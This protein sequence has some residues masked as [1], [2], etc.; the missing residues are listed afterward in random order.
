MNNSVSDS[1]YHGRIVAYAFGHLEAQRCVRNPSYT[2]ERAKT[3]W[4]EHTR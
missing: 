2:N 1:N 4:L 3:E